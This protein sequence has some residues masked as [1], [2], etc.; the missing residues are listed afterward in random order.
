MPTRVEIE[1]CHRE[2]A[3][4]SRRFRRVSAAIPC[5]TACAAAGN[6]TRL[7]YLDSSYITCE[8]DG[9]NRLTAVKNSSGAAVARYTFDWRSRRAANRPRKEQTKGGTTRRGRG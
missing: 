5:E 9:M 6:R 2:S 4:S 7:T 3:T 1:E 8:Y